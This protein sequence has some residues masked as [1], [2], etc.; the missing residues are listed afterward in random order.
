M[1]NAG[2]CGVSHTVSH[3]PSLLASCRLHAD[4]PDSRAS[5][6]KRE[7]EEDMVRIK[8]GKKKKERG[9]VR[10]GSRKDKEDLLH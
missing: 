2:C 6:G 7:G 3:L 8:R 9:G 5:L 1:I 10:F 4:S